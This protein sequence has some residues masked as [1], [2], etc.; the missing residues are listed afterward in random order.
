MSQPD[1]QS[2]R[3][4]I[5]N[6][7]ATGYEADRLNSRSGQLERERTRE[8]LLRFLPRTPATVLDVGGGP[9]AHACWLAKQGYEVHLIDITPLHVEM[10]GA[11]SR[12]QPETPLA[13]ATIGDARSLSW[14]A[15]SADS[16]LLFGP[17]YHLTEREDRVRALTEAHR[18]L[19]PGGILL[20]VAVSRFASAMDGVR[21]GY[22][23]DVRFEE[24]V[25]RDLK[26]GQHR[27]PTNNPEYFMDTF[28]HRPDELRSE[29]AAAGFMVKAVYGVEGPAWL[30]PDFDGWWHRPDYRERLLK[31]ARMVEAE[32]SLLG[33]SAHLMAVASKHA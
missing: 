10:A 12:Q 25:D 27:N 18:V 15:E 1:P 24:I 28:F 29:V 11:A 23:K 7:Y 19:K 3:D 9:G 13:S 6:H 2:Q 14:N 22:L 33:I 26:D 17:L 30:V 16:V 21:M 32:P 4:E 8:L 31:I 5:I 20:A